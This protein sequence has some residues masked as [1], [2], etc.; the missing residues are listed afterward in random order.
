MGPGYTNI[1]IMGTLVT[2]AAGENCAECPRPAESPL[3]RPALTAHRHSPGRRWW[4]AHTDSPTGCDSRSPP[5]IPFA[6]IREHI[7]EIIRL[8]DL[9]E[10][11]FLSK[12]LYLLLRKTDTARL[13]GGTVEKALK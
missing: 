11:L 4:N 8:D 9:A 2:M 13:S 12:A 6:Y 3:S 1:S 7:G 10:H 5:A